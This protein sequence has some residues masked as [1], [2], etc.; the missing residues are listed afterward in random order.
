MQKSIKNYGCLVLVLIIFGLGG[1]ADGNRGKLKR[2]HYNKENELRQNW[3]DYTVYYRGSALLYKFK[4]D[5]KI[6]LDR[7]WVQVTSAAMMAESRIDESTWTQ[8]IRGQ[9]AAL[10][11]YLVQRAADVANV[12]IIDPKTVKLYYQYIRTSGGP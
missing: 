3:Q 5:R 12:K 2:L 11:G 10:Y 7:R 1:C 4:D 8:E 6:E 9:N